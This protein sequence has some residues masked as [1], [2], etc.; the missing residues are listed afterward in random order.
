MDLDLDYTNL[1]E[2]FQNLNQLAASIADTD[3]SL[4]NLIDSYTQWTVSHFGMDLIQMPREESVCQY[5]IKSE[6]PLEIRRLDKDVRFKDKFF[7]SGNGNDLDLKYY[8]GI[9]LTIESGENIGALC[10]LDKEE[11]KMT[12]EKIQQLKFI[13]AE[14]VEHLKLKKQLKIKRLEVHEGL[15]TRNK[16]AHDIRGPLAGIH[17]LSELALEDELTKIEMI[18]YFKM[19]GESSTQLL[20]LTE[21]ILNANTS[22]K[23]PAAGKIRIKDLGDKIIQLYQPQAAYKNI[24]IEVDIPT[25]DEEMKV[26]MDSLLQIIGNLVSNAIKFTPTGGKVKLGLSKGIADDIENLE[27][28]VEDSGSGFSAEKI[29]NILDGKGIS[30]MGTSGEIGFGLGLKLVKSMVEEMGGDFNISTIEN[31]GGRLK[32]TVPQY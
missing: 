26:Y 9:P 30:S 19:I 10:V 12:P 31:S 29:K 4:V 18:S 21:D 23:N 1:Q 24:V 32:M 22:K 6:N 11:K 7:V 15:K 20:D 16:L 13:A 3:I 8:Y 2:E 25:K 5:T 28:R 27:I 17:G 14:I